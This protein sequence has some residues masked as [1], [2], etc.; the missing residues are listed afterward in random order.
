MENKYYFTLNMFATK[1]SENNDSMY[2]PCDL[3]VIMKT[4]KALP[5]GTLC[6]FYLYGDNYTLM[7]YARQKNNSDSYAVEKRSK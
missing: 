3:Q 1:G 7:G 4:G 2:N 6:D 5:E